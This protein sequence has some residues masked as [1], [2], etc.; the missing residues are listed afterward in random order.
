MINYF[1]VDN[2]AAGH[3]YFHEFYFHEFCNHFDDK[4]FNFDFDLIV[5]TYDHTD[6]M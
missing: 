2:S 4:L 1:L 6:L 5:M 3:N